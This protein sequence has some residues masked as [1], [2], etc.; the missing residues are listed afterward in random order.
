MNLVLKAMYIVL[1]IILKKNS[2]QTFFK[3]KIK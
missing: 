1:D 2:N 3:I